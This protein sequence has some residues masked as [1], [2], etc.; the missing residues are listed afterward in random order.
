MTMLRVGDQVSYS[1]KE[2]E[3]HSVPLRGRNRS[4]RLRYEAHKSELLAVIDNRKNLNV[5]S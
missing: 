4:D 5:T 1:V 3:D 2:E